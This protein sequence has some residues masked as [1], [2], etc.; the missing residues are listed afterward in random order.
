MT[1]EAVIRRLIDSGELPKRFLTYPK[2]LQPLDAPTRA[3]RSKP[4]RHGPDIISYCPL[5]DVT[6]NVHRCDLDH[7][8]EGRVTL[9]GVCATCDDY[10]PLTE[11]G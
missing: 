2:R 11:E 4:C 8:H 5:G 3:V 10:Q 7:G 6:Q 1:S 9:G